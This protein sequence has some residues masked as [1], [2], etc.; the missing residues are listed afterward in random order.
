MSST[1]FTNGVTLTDADWFNDVNRLHY[2][3]LGDPADLAAV[4][5]TVVTAAAGGAMVLIQT[6]AASN[7]ATIDFTTGINSTYRRYMILID[8]LVPQTDA[9]T[10]FMRVSEDAGAN[11]KAGLSDYTWGIVNVSA[12]AEAQSGDAAD[13]E[14]EITGAS[15]GTG[16]GESLD[17]EVTFT[18]PAG[19]VLY[20]KFRWNASLYSSAPATLAVE[21]NGVYLS[22]NAINGVRFLMS[23]GNIVSG[24]FSLYGIRTS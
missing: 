13:S 17:A 21:G 19:A 2:T 12:T 14:M 9:T 5:T 1:N 11:W 23:S 6:Q 15:A 18:N 3:I 8:S 4:K 16:T 20:K 10:L 7:S 22:A 24:S